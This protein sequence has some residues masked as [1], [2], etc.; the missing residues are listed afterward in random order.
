[1]GVVWVTCPYNE[2]DGQLNP[3]AR[4]VN[5]TGAFNALADAVLYNTL[6]WVINGSPNYPTNV[7]SWINTWFLASDTYMNPN[8]NYAQIVRGPKTSNFG[9]AA[10][11]LDLRCMVKIVN[12]VLVLR[13]GNAPGWTNAIDS[14]LVAWTKSYIGWLTTSPLALA[15]AATTKCVTLIPSPCFG[16]TSRM[17]HILCHGAYNLVGATPSFGSNHGTYYYGQLAALQILVYDTASANAA[18]QKYFSTLF[19]NQV[20]GTGEQVRDVAQ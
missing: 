7:A 13:A 5:N 19:R 17:S 18:I 8:L 10:G 6:A 2:R 9:R 16:A 12:A 11:V 20:T 15:E 3:D 4:T 14:G 1:L